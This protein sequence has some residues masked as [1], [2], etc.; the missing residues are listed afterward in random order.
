M[1]TKEINACA[2]FLD[3]TKYR[4]PVERLITRGGVR[5]DMSGFPLLIDAIML[6]G[7]NKLKTF[8]EVFATVGEVRK[9]NACTT[10]RAVN[11]AVAAAPLAAFLSKR[12]GIR[13]GPDPMPTG[14]AIAYLSKALIY[15]AEL[16]TDDTLK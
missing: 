12:I 2:E 6:Y 4:E 5:P 16:D 11:Y 15:N 3:N 14:C 8:G 13:L 7:T 1:D 10:K 9:K